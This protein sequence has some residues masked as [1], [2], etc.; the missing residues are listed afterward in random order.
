MNRIWCKEDVKEQVEDGKKEWYNKKKVAIEEGFTKE[1]GNK[2]E[3][4]SSCPELPNSAATPSK[5]HSG[6]AIEDVVSN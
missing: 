4:P 1:R 6:Q 2:K 3:V 5:K